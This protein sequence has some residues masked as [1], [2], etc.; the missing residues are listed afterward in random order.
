MIYVHTHMRV[1]RVSLGLLQAWG[2]LGGGFVEFSIRGEG[3]LRQK[4]RGAEAQG[5][6]YFELSVD[7]IIG[8]LIF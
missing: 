5:L 2:A 4:L 3:E 7:D 8:V 6:I 1:S